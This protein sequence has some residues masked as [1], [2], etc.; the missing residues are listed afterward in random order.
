MHTRVVIVR[1]V[2]NS[3]RPLKQRSSPHAIC[4]SSRHFTS[5]SRLKK[6]REQGANHLANILPSF[7]IHVGEASCY[8]DILIRLIQL[9]SR[10]CRLW[11]HRVLGGGP[12]D[13]W[14]SLDHQ[15]FGHGDASWSHGFAP[16]GFC[17]KV[18][19]HVSLII[20]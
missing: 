8:S 1:D 15:L 3:V 2:V 4:H 20:S 18:K 14:L 19:T 6:N 9:T 7:W 17:A 16:F 5:L 12:E 10:G 13:N 11:I